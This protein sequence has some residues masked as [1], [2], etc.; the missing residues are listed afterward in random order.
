MVLLSQVA[1]SIETVLEEVAEFASTFG[2]SKPETYKELNEFLLAVE[3]LHA[4]ELPPTHWLASKRK[5]DNAE[6]AARTL[7][8]LVQAVIVSESEAGDFTHEALKL[9]LEDHARYFDQHKGLIYGL[10]GNYR[11]RKRVLRAVSLAKN[12]KQVLSD[13][14]KAALW[15]AATKALAK[16]EKAYSGPLAPLYQSIETDWVAVERAIELGQIIQTGL[17]VLEPETFEH[18]LEARGGPKRLDQAQKAL[19]VFLEDWQRFFEFQTCRPAKRI[20]Q[21]PLEEVHSLLSECLPHIDLLLEIEK[22]IRGVVPGELSVT[23][24]LLGMIALRQHRDSVALVAQ[25]AEKLHQSKAAAALPLLTVGDFSKFFEQKLAWTERL[26]ALIDHN[27]DEGKE[28]GPLSKENYSALRAT[29]IPT[30]FRQ[31]SEAWRVAWSNLKSTFEE[32]LGESL[33][34]KVASFSSAETYLSNLKASLPLVDSWLDLKKSLETVALYGLNEAID[35]AVNLGLDGSGVARYLEKSVLAQWLGLQIAADPRL[36]DDPTFGR[37]KFVDE[38]AELDRKITNFSVSEIVRKAVERRPRGTQGEAALIVRE[39]EKKTKHIPVRE[40][41]GRSRNVVQ[42]LQPCFMMSPLAVSQYLPSDIKFDVVIF[43]EASQVTPAEA[44]NCVYRGNALITAGDQKQLPPMSFFAA[45]GLDDE[46][47]EETANDFDSILDLMKASGSFNSLTLN[48]HYRSRHEHLIAFSNLAFYENRLITYPGA[49]QSADDLG[50]KLLKVNGVYRRSTNADNPLEAMEVAKRVVHHF[51]SRPDLSLGVVAFST[52][53]RDAIE[54]AVALER[55][56][57]PYLDKF[58]QG[59]RESGFFVNS[60]EAVQGD[61]RDVII[62]SIGYGPDELGKI[63]KNFGPLNRA[64]GE[65]RLNVAIT[66]ARR[67]VEIVTSMSASQMGE[68]QSEGARHLRKYLDFAERGV[69]ALQVELGDAGLGTESPFEDSVLAAVRSWGYEVQP[70]VG[71]GSYRIDL[72]VKHPNAPGAFILGIEC[73]GAM[74]HSSRTARDRDR[75]RH[76]V[77][78]GL[79]WRLHHIWGTAWY[80]NRSRELEKLR[81]VI[82]EQAALPV[83]GRVV[84]R[85]KAAVKPINVSF[86]AAVAPS[87]EDWTEK[88]EVA[89]GLQIPATVDVSNPAFASYLAP[90][91]D[92][93]VSVEQPVHFDVLAARLRAATGIAKVSGRTRKTLEVAVRLSSAQEEHGF[94]WLGDN[95]AFSVRRHEQGEARSISEIADVELREAVINIVR[96]GIGISKSAIARALGE[97][98]G[99]KRNGSQIQAKSDEIVDSLVL[100]GELLAIGDGYQVV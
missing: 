54:N 26:R 39:A 72:G 60:L 33:D 43:D 90:F 52:A 100:Q 55:N 98:F 20:G 92:H 59:D 61:E 63:Y 25:N 82:E 95:R 85:A 70:Q 5:F 10:S 41:I 1:Q 84:G 58:F 66:R 97:I 11:A 81:Q 79:G 17:Q 22:K 13:L 77:L 6:H 29:E 27:H 46:Q 16:A 89:V 80:R 62:F 2:T 3:Q 47:G 50:V 31:S 40:L 88:Y 87:F 45:S 76:E 24:V 48:W 12:W 67:L 99:W 53:Q 75:L 73:D 44:I 93:V 21:K 68:V 23:S 56:A 38:Y 42:A 94:L 57:R 15:Q 71:V 32:N 7:R 74:Y 28:S 78:E 64:G 86:E 96:H 4:V 83:Q 35:Q 91:V 19:Q 8:P 65:R 18:A 34:E 51:E 14:P 30:D 9:D 36:S 49:I 37:T 69:S